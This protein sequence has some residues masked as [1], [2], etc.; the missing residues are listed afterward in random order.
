MLSCQGRISRSQFRTGPERFV[1][2]G[3]DPSD[4]RI[5]HPEYRRHVN[6]SRGGFSSGGFFFIFGW[7]E[8]KKAKLHETQAPELIHRSYDVFISFVLTRRRTRESGF[9]GC[10]SGE[11]FWKFEMPSP[12]QAAC[13]TDGFAGRPES[14][15]MNSRGSSFCFQTE[16]I[17]RK[18]MLLCSFY[19]RAIHARTLTLEQV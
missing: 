5:C 4:G 8:R 13:S 14:G 18:W 3:G 2:G 12:E 16:S 19:K 6:P 9:F 15:G 11:H 7:D 17:T 1:A 10:V